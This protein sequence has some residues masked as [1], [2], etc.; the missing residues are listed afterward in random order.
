MC[1]RSHAPQPDLSI[2]V[3]VLNESRS[4]PALLETLKRQRGIRFELIVCD[5]GSGDGSCDLLTARGPEQPFACRICRS[6]PGRARQLNAGAACSR[7]DYLLF[8]H[9]DST[10]S[11]PQAL[12]AGYHC[13]RAAHARAGHRNLAGHFAL[14][15]ERT[16]QRPSWAFY[17]HAW[18]ARLHRP[19]CVH[20]D[21]GFMLARAC[22]E[23][24][25]PFDESLPFLEDVRLAERILA[26]DE[27]LLL[28]AVIGTS[29][30]RFESE[31]FYRRQALNA[32]LLSCEDAG[33]GEWLTDLPGIY[34]QQ[35]A[36]AGL[37]LG[38]FFHAVARRAAA[39]PWRQRWALWRRVGRFACGNAWQPALMIDTLRHFRR[40][41]PV[42]AER[43]AVLAWFD[44]H[45]ARRID[46]PAG[47]WGGALVA[48]IWFR[49]RLLVRRWT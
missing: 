40:S 1:P 19:Y 43:L 27:W 17:H 34:R 21:Q 45:V 14:T 24:V 36:C 25:G 20:G 6:L 44:R 32:L 5:G 26:R 8:L 48:W 31:G 11:D 28:P 12:A 41:V 10:F 15:F 23:R 37:R 18:K 16:I 49:W 47:W 33:Y 9:V 35:S 13:L 4:L 29:A 42:G 38:P 7:A 46:C 39:L 30:R 22:F 3:P 2:I